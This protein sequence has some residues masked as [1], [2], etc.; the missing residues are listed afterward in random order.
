MKCDVTAIYWLPIFI[1]R[2][3]RIPQ[4]TWS[5]PKQAHL[6]MFLLSLNLKAYSDWDRVFRFHH[7]QDIAVRE[8]GM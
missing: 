1:C 8:T 7:V 5:E 2:E 6:N 4:E 3:G